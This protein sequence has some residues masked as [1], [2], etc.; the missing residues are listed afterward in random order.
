MLDELR[1]Q[2]GLFIL[3]LHVSYDVL[4]VAHN[5]IA[6]IDE[7]KSLRLVLTNARLHVR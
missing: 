1:S 4:V 3:S 2:P 5:M 6:E 7:V